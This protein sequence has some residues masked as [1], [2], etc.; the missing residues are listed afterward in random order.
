MQELYA[1]ED[2]I[3]D[4]VELRSEM[5]GRVLTEQTIYSSPGTSFTQARKL[6]KLF[7]LARTMTGD[8]AFARQVRRRFL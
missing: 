6:H 1:L 2:L 8:A 4:Y 7:A 5:V 3:A